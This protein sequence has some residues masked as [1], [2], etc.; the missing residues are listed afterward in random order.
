[1]NMDQASS[2]HTNM[3][4]LD[5]EELVSLFASTREEKFFAE[6]YH[7]YRHLSFGICLKMMKDESDSMDVV[8][9]VFRILF[10]KIPTANIKSF[11]SYIYAVSRNECIAKLRKR[12]TELTKMSD[13]KAMQDKPL[14][15]VEN[16]KLMALL[17]N[18]IPLDD[19]VEDAVQNLRAEQQTCVRLFFYENKS[20]KE[21]ADQTG[22]S[23]KQ[24]KSYLQNGKRN[25]RL[26]LEKELQKL[27]A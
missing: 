16:K 19:K 24:V 11:R 9:E 12:K 13:L 5:D 23:E 8:S 18:E 14:D 27:I 2:Q 7:R 15:F 6:L 10:E 26:M 1:M 17:D 21:I 25:L 3:R 20:Y 22:Y 4:N